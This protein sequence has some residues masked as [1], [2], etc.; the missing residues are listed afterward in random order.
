MQIISEDIARSLSLTLDDFTPANEPGAPCKALVTLA[1]ASQ[2]HL[3]SGPG[4]SL[5][6]SYHWRN[7]ETGEIH[8]FD[9]LRTELT[10]SL[11]AGGSA[12]YRLNVITPSDPGSYRFEPSLVQEQVM[13]LDGLAQISPVPAV[14]QVARRPW[15]TT[16]DTEVIYSPHEILNRERFRPHLSYPNG[17]RPIAL[18]VETVNLCN[19]SCIICAYDQQTRPKGT[20]SM[21]LFDRVLSDYSEMGG[22]HLSLTPVVG[23]ALLDRHLVERVR[24]CEDFPAIRSLSFTT[25]AAIADLFDD[26]ELEYILS[27]LRRICISVYG[28]DESEYRKMTRRD[29]Y[30]RLLR[31]IDRILRLARNE[32]VFGFRLLVRREMAQVHE[33]MAQF[34]SYRH[35]Q[36]TVTVTP[37]VYSYS[38]W[39]V[40]DIQSALPDDARWIEI[41]AQ[42]DQCL[43][44][45]LG[46]QVYWDGRV[47]FCPCDD[48]DQ[49]ES[50]SLGSLE[51]ASLGAL[52]SGEK[53]RRL[54]NWR[55]H[56]VPDFC[57]SCSFYR[58]LADLSS[59]ED[60]LEDPLILAGA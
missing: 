4:A 59:S 48:Y 37:P 12:S 53:A 13:W 18:F 40:F 20:M 34:A 15:W 11:P 27:R 54:W 36:A 46:C 9:G 55:A 45:L 17:F 41:P 14:V 38:N 8:V 57:R 44:P 60:I 33:W 22:G 43:I 16:G 21:A 25:N 50:L 19:N 10:P 49:A 26:G 51:E 3:D 5:F 2:V 29:T 35:S 31:G 6:L 58:P 52:C 56:G 47:S 30:Q 23:D 28:L 7:A 1:N 32:V 42:K 24:R 39:G